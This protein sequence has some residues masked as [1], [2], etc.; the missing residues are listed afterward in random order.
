MG[1]AWPDACLSGLGVFW[2]LLVGFVGVLGLL[3]CVFLPYCLL[4]VHILLI[5]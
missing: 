4:Q 2:G 3:V 1:K 5:D